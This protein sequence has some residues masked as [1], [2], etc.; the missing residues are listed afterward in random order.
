MQIL[1]QYPFTEEQTAHLSQSARD[2]GH[3]PLV[4]ADE[5]EAVSLAGEAEVIMG[6]FQPAGCAAAPADS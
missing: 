1:I 3:E 6:H 2:H 4:A 5:G